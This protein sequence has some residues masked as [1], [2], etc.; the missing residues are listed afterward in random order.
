MLCYYGI[1]ERLSERAAFFG[2]DGHTKSAT[3]AS[4]AFLCC[5][6]GEGEFLYESI[7]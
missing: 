4:R 7:L 6:F 3:I 1:S 2:D 5:L